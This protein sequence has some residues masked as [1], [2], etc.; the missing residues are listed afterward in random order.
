MAAK[1]MY[2]YLDTIAADVDYTLGAAPY[3]VH[4]DTVIP[5]KGVKNQEVYLGD[6]NSRL[7]ISYSDATL[8][9]VSLQSI[10]MPAAEFGILWDFWENVLIGNGRMNTWKWAHPDDGHV[11]VVSWDCDFGQQRNAYDVYQWVDILLAVWGRIAD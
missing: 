10:D 4:F 8:Y 2:D 6:D 3:E 9:G 1:E 7:A 5:I 11:Y